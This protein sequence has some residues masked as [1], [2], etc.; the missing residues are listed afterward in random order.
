MDCMYFFLSFSCFLLWMTFVLGIFGSCLVLVLEFLG[1]VGIAGLELLLLLV[2]PEPDVP[3]GVLFIIGAGTLGSD[4]ESLGP[5]WCCVAGTKG[6][7]LPCFPGFLDSAAGP[8]GTFGR[9][10]FWA[11]VSLGV[12]ERGPTMEAVIVLPSYVWFLTN[13]QL[14]LIKSHN[15]IDTRSLKTHPHFPFLSYFRIFNPNFCIS[16]HK[17]CP[18]K[19]RLALICN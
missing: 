17:I 19:E 5:S 10:R 2:D 8:L 7:I 1:T 3:G 16:I 14:R 18:S 11:W 6:S 12:E 13:V 9:V 4:L 15:S